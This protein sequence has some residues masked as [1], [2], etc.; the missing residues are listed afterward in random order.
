MN[1][2]RLI[3]GAA[4]VLAAAVCASAQGAG[5]CTL[6]PSQAPEIRGLR[7]GMTTAQLAARYPRLPAVRAD[8]FGQAQPLFANLPNYGEAGLQGVISIRL[9]FIDDRL[10]DYQL[11]YEEAPWENIDQFLTKVKESFRLP[12][13]WASEGE[14][15]RRLVCDHLQIDVGAQQWSAVSMAAYVRVMESG[16]DAV[17]RRRVAEKRERQRQAFKP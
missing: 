3:C 15:R 9:N 6:K 2:S 10:V 16:A 1:S 13:A 11:T 14:T 4:L 12:D 7:L 17:I 8:E 5:T